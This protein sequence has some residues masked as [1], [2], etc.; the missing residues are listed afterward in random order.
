MI[1]AEEMKSAADIVLSKGR[2]A[3]VAR[4]IPSEEDLAAA[5]AEARQS[6]NAISTTQIPGN[7]ERADISEGT[8]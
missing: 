8:A 1:T 6:N 3:E 5:A 4:G 7:G 2:L